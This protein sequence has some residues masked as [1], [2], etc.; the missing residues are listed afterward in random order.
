MEQRS[1]Y[2]I[3]QALNA[4]FKRSRMALLLFLL[5]FVP[6]NVG[7]M[8]SAP[9][10]R[11]SAKML[12]S[13]TRIYPEIS[14]LDRQASVDRP[15][16]E[17]MINSEVQLLRSR[18]LM[19]LVQ[20]ELEARNQES[21]E[22]RTIPGIRALE[23]K[24]SVLRKPGSNVIEV[25]FR[26]SDEQLAI[27]VVNTLIG[28][29]AEYSI[30]QHTSTGAVDFFRRQAEEARV[31]FEN[32]DLTLE[33]YDAAHGLTSIAVEKDQLLRQRAQLEAD[34]RRTEAEVTELAT[35]A[36]A[37]EAELAY[38]PEHEAIEV[39]MIPNPMIGFLRQNLA[40][41]E[42]EQTRLLRLYTPQHRL[43]MDVEA[44]IASLR[45]QIVGE[46]A[47]IIGRKRMATT[48]VRREVEEDL[49][50]SQADLGAL[51]A[52]RALLSDRISDYDS[53][54][55][56]MHTKHY[57]VMRLRR[58]RTQ[59][60]MTYD[61]V[62]DKLNKLEVSAAMD[63]AGLANMSV[64]EAAAPPL[65]AEPDFKGVT[66]VLSLF[67]ALLLGV[68]SAVVTEMLNP[69]MNSEIDIRHHLGLPVLAEIPL[70]GLESNGTGNGNGNGNGE[71]SGVQVG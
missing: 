68:A 14:P 26:S 52:R 4:V 36:A 71:R 5:I 51:E 42:M 59:K 54:I 20:S 57:Q 28:Q 63:R 25:A 67:A 48:G 66:F 45:G 50:G 46:E 30:E 56:V 39:D 21:G 18:D 38:I 34:M 33:R 2:L 11:A 64:V 19:R 32:A 31:D 12:L 17:A 70:N 41:M 61:A 16:N 15:P 43:V 10:Y 60:R 40:R 8:A 29:Y 53:R 58:E 37:L 65:R 27:D 55:R 47:S 9:S 1:L 62:I 44:E 69:V 7:N 23:S 22:D 6:V 24:L 49:L 13:N 3:R 35:R